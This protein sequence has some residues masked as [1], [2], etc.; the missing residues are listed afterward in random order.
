MNSASALGAVK[1]SVGAL[2][3]KK[4]EATTDIKTHTAD[5][6]SEKDESEEDEDDSDEDEAGPRWGMFSRGGNEA[7]ERIFQKSMTWDELWARHGHLVSMEPFIEAMDTS[8]REELTVRFDEKL[9][10]AAKA[11][12][13]PYTSVIGYDWDTKYNDE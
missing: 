11:A 12:G 9:H 10:R 7:I 6:P 5:K 4:G 1:E 3:K 2:T 13:K 8:V